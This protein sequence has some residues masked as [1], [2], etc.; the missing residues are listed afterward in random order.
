VCFGVSDEHAPRTEQ[1]A[2]AIAARIPGA[3]CKLGTAAR[4]DALRLAIHGAGLL[5]V[6]AHARFVPAAPQASGLRLADGW[7]TAADVL[8]MRLAG[9]GVVL[10]ACDSGRSGV[11][12]SNDLLGLIRAFLVAG[13]RGVVSSLWPLHDE[14]ALKIMVESVGLGYAASGFS[15][16]ID[17]VRDAQIEQAKAGV[18]PA[19]WAPLFTIGVGRKAVGS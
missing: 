14:T 11:D 8:R 15:G 2:A 19:F 6:A 18:H 13:A 17:R 16:V 4:C 9:A 7:L 12:A 3:L 5:H 10:S 1:E